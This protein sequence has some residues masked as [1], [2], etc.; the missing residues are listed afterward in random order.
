MENDLNTSLYDPDNL[1]ST[2]CGVVNK[3]KKLKQKIKKMVIK[4]IM[5]DIDCFKFYYKEFYRP[6]FLGLKDYSNIDDIRLNFP[7]CGNISNEMETSRRSYFFHI[8]WVLLVNTTLEV[9]VSIKLIRA[10]LANDVHICI[11]ADMHNIWIFVIIK[12]IILDREETTTSTKPLSTEFGLLASE[13]I[14]PSTEPLNG[15]ETKKILRCTCFSESIEAWCI[16]GSRE[17]YQDST[18]IW[19]LTTG[20]R[21]HDGADCLESNFWWWRMYP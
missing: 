14:S 21:R 20:L 7:S 1:S 13:T 9:R 10:Y 17:L 4:K 11:V 15:S 3:D 8:R 16:L 6:K 5:N 19:T 2:M 18:K 12:R